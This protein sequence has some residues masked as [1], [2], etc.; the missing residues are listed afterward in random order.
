MNCRAILRPSSRVARAA[1]A[2]IAFFALDSAPASSADARIALPAPTGN[3][4]I[5]RATF[6]WKDDSRTE[7]NTPEDDKREVR[8]DLWYPAETTAT[9]ERA[10]YWPEL[11]TLRKQMSGE[12]FLFGGLKTHAVAAAPVAKGSTQYPLLIFSPGMGNNAAQSTALIEELVS[13][14][15]IVAAVDHPYQSRAIAFPDGRAAFVLQPSRE[16]LASA[17]KAHDDYHQRVEVRSADMRFVLDRLEHMNSGQDDKQFAGRIDLER[18]GAIGHSIGG[19]G[20]AEACQDDSRFR[21]AINMDG[22]MNSLPFIPDK[23]GRGPRQPFLELT[24]AVRPWTD[25]ELAKQKLTREEAERRMRENTKRVDDAMR[26]VA[27]GAFRVSIPG[28]RHQSFADTVVLD[29]GTPAERNRRI[30]IIRDYVRAFF[31][32]VLLKKERTLLDGESGPYPD[33]TVERFKPMR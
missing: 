14:G 10:A 21:A 29:P 28:A 9:A 22:H 5:G 12:S 20:A 25:Q 17:P 2:V 16:Q 13:H 33:V 27:G 32:K 4:P 6:F 3:L 8:V 15:Y 30:Q 24:D 1:V 11:T 19:V 7:L 18:V 31:D 26:T 23:D